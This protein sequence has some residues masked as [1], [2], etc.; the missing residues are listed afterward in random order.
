[1]RGGKIG[2]VELD[3]DSLERL[4]PDDVQGGDTTGEETL[5]LH[6]ERYEFAARHLQ[7]GRLLDLAC[8]VGY[9]TRL[10]C[11]RAEVGV[12]GLGVDI[13]QAAVDYALS[14]Y[15]QDGTS[16]RCA[17]A[18]K[19]SDDQ[20]FDN[21]VSIETIEHLPDPQGFADRIVGLLRPGGVLVSS[22]PVTPSVDANPHHLHDFSDRSFRR[23]FTRHG[24]EAFAE[25]RQDQP[26]GLGAVVT[27]SEPRMQQIRP[28]L[29]L[30]YLTHPGSLVRR[31][32]STLQHGFK[33]VY[34]TVAWRAPA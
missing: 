33:N 21:I 32:L 17:D 1:M 29:P 9:G 14:H 25:F 31:A 27:R 34:L 24:L 7:T 8:G 18:M 19:F 5:R 15:A 28:N 23:L 3:P 22:V 16:Y 26:F 20:G 4:V 2:G 30:W 10:L 6:L 12:E 13:S 11:D